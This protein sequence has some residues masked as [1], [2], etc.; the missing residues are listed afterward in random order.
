MLH[1]GYQGILHKFKEAV[2]EEAVEKWGRLGLL[3]EN[4]VHWFPAPV[5]VV[6]FDLANDP[7]NVQSGLF[8]QECEA[9]M[10]LMR[11]MD[12]QKP[13]FYALMW[14]HLSP[15]SKDEIKRHAD[16]GVFSLDKEP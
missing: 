13:M 12:E 14:K 3:I 2:S 16:W 11:K 8:K 4:G 10:K 15:E 7:F 5:D 6:S 9:R 1:Y